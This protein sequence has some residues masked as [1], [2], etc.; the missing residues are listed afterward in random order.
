MT[1]SDACA[2]SRRV[3]LERAIWVLIYGGLLLLLCG[4]VLWRQDL[5]WAPAAV[6]LGAFAAV[7]GAALIVLRARL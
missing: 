4:I 6:A 3:W 2:A 7:A 5:A 1:A